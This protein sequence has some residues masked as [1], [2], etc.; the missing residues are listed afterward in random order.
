MPFGFCKP[1]LDAISRYWICSDILKANSTALGWPT[2]PAC[3]LHAAVFFPPVILGLL[4]RFHKGADLKRLEKQR[5]SWALL[6]FFL[7]LRITACNINK[8]STSAVA[9]TSFSPRRQIKG[10]FF[11]AWKLCKHTERQRY[12]TGK[13]QAPKKFVEKIHCKENLLRGNRGKPIN[14]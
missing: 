4:L 6:S 2:S 7:Q 14:F 1:S 3:A 12:P 8:S 10:Q 11:R 5:N 13:L 9:R